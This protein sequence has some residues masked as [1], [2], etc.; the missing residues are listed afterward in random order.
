VLVRML[1]S[2]I[3]PSD[4]MYVRGSYTVAPMLPA[5]P[6]FEG[7]GTVE[8][9]GGGLIGRLLVGRRVVVMN[10]RAGNWAEYAVA[11]A[12]QCIPV[13]SG[14]SDNQAAMFFVNPATALAITHQILKVPSGDWLL[15]TA[16]GS[17]L[18]KMV[19][20]L[21]KDADFRTINVVR[22]HEQIEVLKKLGA[23][24][25]LCESD[26]PLPDQVR[27]IVPDGV[28]FAMDPVGGTTGSQAIQCLA[29]GG[30]LVVYGSLSGEPITIDPRFLIENR[31]VQGFW[32]G[33]WAKSQSFIQKIQLI[34]QIR[35]LIQSGILVSDVAEAFPLGRISEAVRKAAAP[36]R[37]GKVLLSIGAKP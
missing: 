11:N 29:P 30:Q 13:P 26:G 1:A 16:A 34:R 9:S 17:A 32:L 25:V 14:L 35:K 31:K 24:H 22:R 21:G 15:Q 4:L 33:N 12:R 10:D 28:R 36:A 5:T 6:G 19:I 8:S 18:G 27:K 3:N 23:D 7:V 20:R 37:G 2:P